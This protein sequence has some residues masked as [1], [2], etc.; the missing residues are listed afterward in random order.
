MV[1]YR[2]R[3]WFLPLFGRSWAVSRARAVQPATQPPFVPPRFGT[4]RNLNRETRGPEVAAKMS[5]L[6]KPAMPWQSHSLDVAL[7]IDPAT[8]E[9]WYEEVIITVPRQSGKSTLILALLLWRCMVLA[10]SLGAQTVTYIAQTGKM[11]RRKLEREF[12]RLLRAADKFAEIPRLSKQLPKEPNQWKLSMNNGN[13]HIVFGTDSYFQIEAPGELSSHGDVL[14]V[15]V[16]D[17]AW[18]RE[19]DSVE[20][21]TDA[22]TVTRRSPQSWVVSTAGNKRSKWFARKVIGGRKAINDP[23]SRTCYLEWSVPEDEANWDKPEVWARYLPALGFTITVERL[24]ARLD[25]AQRN[26]DEVDEDG[27][28]PGIAGW[29][30]GYLNIWPEWP[31][32]GGTVNINTEI[33]I[34]AWESL[35]VEGS[36]IV[37]P[38]VFGI[39]VGHEGSSA[40][41][42]VAG[43]TATGTAQIETIERELGTWWLEKALRDKAAAHN[44]VVVA[45][46]NGGTARMLAPEIHRGASCAT[47]PAT[48]APLT[49]VEWHASCQAFKVRISEQRLVHLGDV[50]LSDALAVAERQESGDGWRW[51]VKG[52]RGDMAALEAATAALRALESLPEPSTETPW[53]FV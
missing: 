29:K 12:A 23:T 34:E 17:E 32:F 38:V 22:A 1:L 50:H 15:S 25:K 26:P 14:D 40:S 13:E 46:N 10:S 19:D 41:I 7:E 48:L 30:R 53:L 49:G 5:W 39:G 27:F 2:P 9:L 42:A 43:Y 52:A 37:G 24:Q 45:W 4:P 6:G 20:Q 51:Q 36:T 47:P 18:S 33:S 3:A 16:T 8:G 21:A 31:T 35:K 11:A 28:E 44:P